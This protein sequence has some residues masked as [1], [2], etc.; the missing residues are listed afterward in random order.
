MFSHPEGND[1]FYLV[2]SACH[3]G[4]WIQITA[5]RYPT[6]ALPH[7]WNTQNI[8]RK[9]KKK[10]DKIDKENKEIVDR[11]QKWQTRPWDHSFIESKQQKRDQTTVIHTSLHFALKKSKKHHHVTTLRKHIGQLPK[12]EHRICQILH[13]FNIPFHNSHM[14]RPKSRDYLQIIQSLQPILTFH[15]DKAWHLHGVWVGC[16]WLSPVNNILSLYWW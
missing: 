5:S 7:F 10:K 6:V 15:Y 3:G 16:Q 1:A 4:E 12:T 2:I 9:K 11:G 8:W 14:H 13:S